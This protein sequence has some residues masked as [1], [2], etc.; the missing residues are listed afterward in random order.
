[1]LTYLSVVRATAG[2]NEEQDNTKHIANVKSELTQFTELKRTEGKKSNNP[3]LAFNRKITLEE[4][5]SAIKRMLKKK[6]VGLDGIPNECFKHGNLTLES[7]ILHLFNSCLTI[8]HIPQSWQESQTIL[9]YKKGDP[10]RIKNY[11]PITLLNSI[12][13]LWERILESR[14]RKHLETN[15]TISQMK[16]GS[17]AKRGTRDLLCA[18]NTV[19]DQ[20][21][22][23][24]YAVSVDL[25]KA[26]NRVK[27]PLL[28]KKSTKWDSTAIYGM[29]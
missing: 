5:R 17:R 29:P 18:L 9:L 4:F 2:I 14:A 12:F 24:T 25:S 7:Y 10:S 3:T 27:R 22:K 8:R 28:W 16:F 6:A 23:T 15:N 21:K 19:L 20:V 11:R 13:K 1:M 26:Y